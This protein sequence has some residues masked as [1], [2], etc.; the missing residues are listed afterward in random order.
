MHQVQDII[1]RHRRT[2]EGH[3]PYFPGKIKPDAPTPI[4]V[5]KTQ[6]GSAQDST[7]IRLRTIMRNL[8]RERNYPVL[9]AAPYGPEFRRI[10]RVSDADQQYYQTEAWNAVQSCWLVRDRNRHRSAAEMVSSLFSWDDQSHRYA[11]LAKW[12][13]LLEF[14]N[15][16]ENK[17]V[18]EDFVHFL[19][20]EDSLL[21]LYFDSRRYNLRSSLF[22]QP[23]Q[24]A[25]AWVEGP[26]GDYR[27]QSEAVELLQERF[28]FVR[29]F[30]SVPK[31]DYRFDIGGSQPG[32][33]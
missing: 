28:G 14:R 33:N 22:Y 18:L 17:E 13:V 1:S 12:T 27:L 9:Y 2:L 26:R 25:C 5:L 16:L 24:V 10:I 4:A 20:D 21:A 8:G 15:C 3:E 31:D 11:F 7:V 32:V 23:V 6:F 19:P 29:D 30:A